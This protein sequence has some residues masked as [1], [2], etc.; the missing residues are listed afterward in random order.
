MVLHVHRSERSDPLVCALSEL[1]LTPPADPFAAE[2]IA[3]PAKGVERWLTQRL[4]H[5]LGR[6][7][8]DAGDGVCANVRFPS[9]AGLVGEVLAATTGVESTADPWARDRLTWPLLEVLGA[10]SGEPW[11]SVLPAC[12]YSDAVHVATLFDAYAAVRPQLILDWAAGHDTDGAG[13]PLPLDLAWQPQLWRR[14]RDR[15]GTASPAERLEPACRRLRS[16]PTVVD[17][18]ERL[19]VFG[20]TRLTTA[21]LAVLDALAAGREV[22][23]WLVHPSAALWRRTSSAPPSGGSSRRRDDPAA[24][25]VRHP[26]LASL[27]RDARELQQ[28]LA[29]CGEHQEHHHP[30]GARAP[31]LLGRLQSA[32]ASDQPPAADSPGRPLLDDDD[33]SLTVHACHGPARQVEVL[34]E[35][36]VGLLAADPTLEPR[37][38]LVMCPDIEEYAPLVSATFGLEADGAAGTHPGHR[39]QVRLADRS[40][41]QTNPLLAALSRLLELAAG[42]VTASEVLDFAS[43]APVRRRF[44]FSDDDLELLETWVSAAGIRWG[45]DA[46]AR[47]RHGLAGIPQN[48]WRAGLDRILLGAAMADDGQRWVGLALPLD[49]VDSNDIGVA[50]RF[51]ELLDRLAAVLADLAGERPLAGWLATLEQALD[52]LTA[53]GEPDSW[54]P[55]HAR[56][57]LARVAADGGERASAVR[58]GLADV[59]ALLAERL[60]GRPTRA[61]FRTGSLTVCSMVPMRSVPHRV[62]CLLGLDDGAF[63]RGGSVDGDDVLARDPCV[64]ERDRR[65]EDRQILLD[66]VLAARERLVVLYTGADPRTN[67][68]RPPAVPVGEL[69]DAVDATVRSPSGRPVRERILVQH[70]LQPFDPRNFTAG[71]LG[72]PGP[73]SFDR[74]ALRGAERAGSP[75]EP[76]RP[77]LAEPL[78]APVHEGD[79][80]LSDLVAFLEHPVQAF[81]RQRLGLTLARDDERV[82]DELFVDLDG[83]A[84]WAVG[85]RLLQSRLAGHDP[86]ACLQAEWRRGTLPPGRLGRTILGE[87]MSEVEALVAA[88]TDVAGRESTALDV[89]LDLA[90]RRLTGTIGGI[91]ASTLVR[92][93]YSRLGPKHRL[94]AWAHLLAL[95]ASY[96]Q[97]RWSAVTVGRGS[98]PGE[99]VRSRL[100][101]VDPVTARAALTDL[102]LLYAQGMREPLPLSVDAA[103]AYSGRRVRGVS[104]ANATVVAEREWTGAF[105]G[106]KHVAHALVWG[107][108]PPFSV[109]LAEPASPDSTARP[110]TAGPA[111]AQQDPSAETTAFGALARRVWEPLLAAETLVTP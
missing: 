9:P 99:V 60:R 84:R 75:R 3:V 27:G 20:P 88:S 105:E 24:E 1:L 25:L 67:A 89:A 106:S 33:R 4:A 85:D 95:S 19:S 48:T 78:T 18:P 29:G 45:L 101:P 79:L 58:L 81:L 73:F 32:L 49:D 23:L 61:N 62:I 104:A 54:Q 82:S 21:Q 8:A 11:C 98:R 109:L 47:A 110:G 102:V 38:V 2:V 111:A 68:R 31:T 15:L 97:A 100:G 76:V 16:E 6:Q 41:R 56:R 108:D 53:V 28:Q 5:V 64:G 90:G 44:R 86:Q 74:Q 65:S 30:L 83:L 77:F 80:S 63:P 7:R 52:A 14:V 37:D 107:E 22:H 91:C 40:L 13:A 93:V 66:A 103:A 46:A 51:A 71:A 26:L 42:R 96:P 59:S 72:I 87:L 43:S 39:L 55:A 17:L 69:L 57:E 10:C 70:P 34:R 50:G 94:R 92:V 36:L 12:S 35:L